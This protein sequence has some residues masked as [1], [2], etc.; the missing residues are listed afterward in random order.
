[1]TTG[2]LGVNPEGF[3]VNP[4][5]S[6]VDPEGFGVNP[7]GLGVDPKTIIFKS[8]KYKKGCKLLFLQP[9]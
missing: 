9:F 5:G 3:G 8:N 7:E 2:S 6:G 1:M 4:E